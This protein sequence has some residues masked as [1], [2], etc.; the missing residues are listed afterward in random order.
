MS[1][2]ANKFLERIQRI[3][4]LSGEDLRKVLHALNFLIESL[5]NKDEY[6]ASCPYFTPDMSYP[7]S[8]GDLCYHFP[9]CKRS[10]FDAAMDD[11]YYKSIS[12]EVE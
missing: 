1:E 12:L 5:E 11:Y 8:A 6:C 7:E 2:S 10:Y 3:E 4:S 9:N